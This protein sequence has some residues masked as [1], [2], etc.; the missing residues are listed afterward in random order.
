MSWERPS[1][2]PPSR[3]LSFSN[4]L[5][6]F[7]NPLGGDS[8]VPRRPISRALLT[9]SRLLSTDDSLASLPRIYVDEAPVSFHE[10]S[11]EDIEENGVTATDSGS[12]SM[13]S[14][15]VA[16]LSVHDRVPSTATT[17][18]KRRSNLSHSIHISS[19]PIINQPVEATDAT[20]SPDFYETR[21]H[22]RSAMSTGKL[23]LLTH[24]FVPTFQTIISLIVVLQVPRILGEVGILQM[25]LIALCAT[26][27]T[28]LTAVSMSVVGSSGGGWKRARRRNSEPDGTQG[29]KQ[30]RPT[31]KHGGVYFLVSR[32]LGRV[33]GGSVSFLM[34]VGI[35]TA[36]VVSANS[37]STVFL[38]SCVN[39]WIDSDGTV[40]LGLLP[41]TWVTRLIG[42]LFL[43]VAAN[44]KPFSPLSAK[45]N[46]H[47]ISVVS[48]FTF[49]VSCVGFIA[50]FVGVA[51][52][53][54]KQGLSA[55]GDTFRQNWGSTST[56]DNS[57]AG[58]FFAMFGIFFPAV[59][60]VLAGSSRSAELENPRRD[61]PRYTIS[62]QISTSIL[63]FVLILL[64]G[65]SFDRTTLSAN[66]LAM[67]RDA[68]FIASSWPV[69][70]IAVAGCF[71]ICLG[72]AIQGFTSATKLIHAIAKDDLLPI[73]NVFKP[74]DPGLHG[75]KRVGGGWQ[76]RF[77][78]F[79][80]AEAAFLS[81]SVDEINQV[82]TI[83][84]LLCYVFV[85][86]ATAILAFIESP[87]WTPTWKYHH[88]TLSAAASI[89]SLVFSFFISLPI[90]LLT[91]ALLLI[92]IKFVA[93]FDAKSQYG[94]GKGWGGAAGVL[95]QIAK[96]NLWEVEL[97]TKGDGLKGTDWRP[98]VMLF[99]KGAIV[100]NSEVD[101]TDKEVAGEQKWRLQ[102][103][104]AVEFL[105][106]LKKGG[107]L[108]TVCTVRLGTIENLEHD[109]IK[110]KHIRAELASSV[111]QFN[112][113]AFS[114]VIVSPTLNEG[115][116]SACQCSGI[117][118]L[119]PNTIMMGFPTVLTTAFVHLL[120]SVI[121]LD[122]AIL[123]VKGYPDFPSSENS[124]FVHVP[125]TPA[126][127]FELSEPQKT[128]DLYWI[129]L[130]GG[131]LT[132]IAHIILKHAAWRSCKLRIFV[133]ANA[134]DN[135]VLMKR[136]LVET[137]R[138]LRIK[139]EADVLE[140]DF[141]E[142]ERNSGDSD[143][144]LNIHYLTVGRGLFGKDHDTLLEKERQEVVRQIQES[145]SLMGVVAGPSG[146]NVAANIASLSRPTLDHV[147]GIGAVLGSVSDLQRGSA[148]APS[149]TLMPPV[150]NF[151]TTGKRLWA[152][153]PLS[154]SANNRDS[155][156]TMRE[157]TDTSNVT[158]ARNALAF[159]LNRVIKRT[160]GNARL[161]LCNL[162]CPSEAVVGSDEA[163]EQE[164]V[165]YLKTLSKDLD[166]I[167]FIK[168]TG[169]EVVTDFY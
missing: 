47:H 17:L 91:L 155:N 94:N 127:N 50:M 148:P 110:V 6:F 29:Q 117:G 79:A 123:L 70:W 15:L 162:P 80:I 147:V 13:E 164:Y 68:L 49:I 134:R 48:A 14:D 45:S 146:I 37:F 124:H 62:A 21:R 74:Q 121:L 90:T 28:L 38:T 136:N 57:S 41:A 151:L 108:A 99:V 82:V 95:M 69:K 105:A 35:C 101:G 12:F 115:I 4:P 133:V 19:T 51:R 97:R 67:S 157:E 107:G 61:I 11:L 25:C 140:L 40:M 20:R 92:L 169:L 8:Q 149:N 102:E 33:V 88:W 137:L 122:K 112:L 130:D 59:T 141:D 161:I 113:A 135:S 78:G 76:A 167:V 166:H 46:F 36:V 138:G 98:H 152:N 87:S 30:Q 144:P 72:A 83:I 158:L 10:A 85:N 142:M 160:S 60:G 153:N 56:K 5:D 64:L 34:Y 27:L 104:K 93:S 126:E 73:L 84:Y 111:K 143:D 118:P 65:F 125:S 2:R 26:F 7:D 103:E 156:V 53:A 129:L 43:L 96:R 114:Q 22:R 109:P 52:V 23:P 154:E 3:R 106:Q 16:S 119:R 128:L 150:N 1:P 44:L 75:W 89:L 132:L 116:L 66:K 100:E 145:N 24:I 77:F 63:Y 32:S 58:V 71:S 131:I 168:G 39:S 18:L 9:R 42:T 159:K 81:G 86:G 54:A 31:G 165:E 55:S 163:G 139:A 120:R